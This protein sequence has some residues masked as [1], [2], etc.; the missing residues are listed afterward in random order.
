M[1]AWHDPDCTVV[2]AFLEKSSVGWRTVF[3]T[4]PERRGW[5]HPVAVHYGVTMIPQ[6]W[7]VDAEGKTVTTSIAT[8]DLDATL[9]KLLPPAK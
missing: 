1:S 5:N 8:K 7:L 9:A 4:A 6:I 3:H 2:D